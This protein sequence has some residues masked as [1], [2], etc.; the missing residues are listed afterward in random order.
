[1]SKTKNFNQNYKY[2]EM[3]LLGQ[4]YLVEYIDGDNVVVFLGWCCKVQKRF[5]ITFML[6]DGYSKRH[7]FLDS[8]FLVSLHSLTSYLDRGK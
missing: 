2:K 8:P 6:S 4:K 5:P 3:P 7:F 1:M